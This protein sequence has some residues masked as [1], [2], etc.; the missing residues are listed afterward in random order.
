MKR[1]IYISLGTLCVGLGII[2]AFLPVMPTTIFL[3]MA[4]YFYARSSD[5]LYGKLMAHPKFGPVIRNWEEHR[6]MPRKARIIALT[7]TV[8]GT[9]GA[10]FVP[11]PWFVK[12]GLVVAAVVMIVILLR[13]QTQE[14]R[15]ALQEALSSAESLP[16]TLPPSS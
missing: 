14:S 5:R 7:M 15:E 1:I 4:A 12:I 3:I 11:M 16:V 6:T 2:G 9:T 10:M 8:L 13:I